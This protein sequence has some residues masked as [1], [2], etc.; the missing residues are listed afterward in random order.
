MVFPINLLCSVFDVT[1]IGWTRADEQPS[2][3]VYGPT[4]VA[5]SNEH[6]FEFFRFRLK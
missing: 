6:S 1:A 3:V 5:G 2:R 4:A